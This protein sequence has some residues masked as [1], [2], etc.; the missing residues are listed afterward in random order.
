MTTAVCWKDSFVILG[1]CYPTRRMLP[2]FYSLPAAVNTCERVPWEGPPGSP[3]MDWPSTGRPPC[4]CNAHMPLRCLICYHTHQHWM[5]GCIPS[6][7]N[8]CA[9]SWIHTTRRR[10]VVVFVPKRLQ[11]RWQQN[12]RCAARRLRTPSGCCAPA[13]L[14]WRAQAYKP[15]GSTCVSAP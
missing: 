1:R 15:A 11:L 7:P 3:F 13:G 10:A 4:R 12:P 9:E 2:L 5:S 6:I 8:L 14:I